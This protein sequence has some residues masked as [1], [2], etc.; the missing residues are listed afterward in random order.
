MSQ[1]A[2]EKMDQVDDDAMNQYLETG[3]APLPF[4]QE[5]EKHAEF[6]DT[7]TTQVF[8]HTQH[9]AV[10]DSTT[11]A[12]VVPYVMPRVTKKEQTADLK[13]QTLLSLCLFRYT[14]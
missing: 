12:E 1:T 10:L 8:T 2:F 13:H 14:M 5:N 6:E 3:L 4:L 9:A 7:E 11:V